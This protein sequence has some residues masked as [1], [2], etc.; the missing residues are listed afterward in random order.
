MCIRQHLTR[1]RNSLAIAAVAVGLVVGAGL[2]AAARGGVAD[3]AHG[4][5]RWTNLYNPAG[6]NAAPGFGSCFQSDCAFERGPNPD[7]CIECSWPE[8][9]PDYHGSNG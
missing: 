5:A 9:L 6:P 8:G 1:F 7:F 2:P 3:P 4:Q